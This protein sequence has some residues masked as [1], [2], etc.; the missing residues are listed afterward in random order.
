MLL[1]ELFVVM[2]LPKGEAVP[3][4]QLAL[5]SAILVAVALLTHT[6]LIVRWS[7]WCYSMVPRASWRELAGKL[8][9]EMRTLEKMVG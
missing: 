3:E 9:D 1:I 6:S 5:A 7:W 2:E 4:L 8:L